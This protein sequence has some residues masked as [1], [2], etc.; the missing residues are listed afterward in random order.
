M[1]YMFENR[2]IPFYI[3]KP[4]HFWPTPHIHPHLEL[5]YLTKGSCITYVDGQ[6]FLLEP[7]NFFL[8]FPN[9]IHFYHDQS[10][11]EGYL[12]IFALDFFKDLKDIF[13]NQIPTSPII[14]LD[15]DPSDIEH[16]L[17]VIFK[18]S[19]SEV[20]LDKIIA[21]GHLLALLGELLSKTTLIDAPTD[22]DNVKKLLVYCSENY[23]E[24]LNLDN[25]SHKLHLSKYYISHI[26]NDKLHVSFTDFINS[27]RVEHACAHLKK[28]VNIT[29]VALSSGFL[30]VR[31]FNRTF[32]KQMNMTPR[33]Y[34]NQKDFTL[35][36]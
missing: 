16:R 1:Q 2:K 29:D 23:T 32:M 15:Y 19:K 12:L 25:V 31:T 34:I 17:E 8:S 6:S 14:Q 26:F 9:Q 33:D 13:R 5:I 24:P 35:R 3:N 20:A 36:I 22:Y 27:L 4:Q 21:N 18:K 11:V 10:P 30:S 28:G 7:G